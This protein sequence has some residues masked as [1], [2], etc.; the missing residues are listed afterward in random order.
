MSTQPLLAVEN[1]AVSFGRGPSEVKAVQGASFTV[2]HGE[3]VALVG[4]SGSGKSATALSIMR[5][6]PYPH[7]WHPSGTI[8]FQDE[9]LTRA[10]LKRM[11]ALRGNRI[12]MIFQE[13][14]T[15]LSP[16]HPVGR[17][18]EEVLAVHSADSRRHL[19]AR[20]AELLHLVGFEEAG[21]RLHALPHEFSGGQQQRL[22]I[23]IA[24]AN[25]PDLLIADEPTTA[26]DVTI[27]AQI[28][29][30]L[31]DL[32]GSLQMALLLIT[33]DLGIVRRIAE[34]VCV[35]KDGAIVE[36][37]PCAEVLSRPRHPYTQALLAAEP[38]GLPDPPPASAQ[39]LLRADAA[40]VWLPI[41]RGV[42]RRTVG[43]V[44][45]VDGVS[46]SV[47]EGHTLGVVG[48][49]GSGKSTLGRALLRL[50]KSEGVIAF[51]GQ[52]LQGFGWKAL[53]PLRRRMQI[54]FQD[55]FGSLSPRM[56]VGQ[57]VGEG[58]VIHRLCASKA[59]LEAAV[60]RALGEVGL[61]PE[62]QH[63]YPHEFSGGQRQRIAIARALVLKPKLIVLDEPTSA[64]DIS[65]QAQIV[66][67]L[68]T[69]QRTHGLA[70]IFISH[71]LRVVRA[72]AHDLLVLR[73]GRVVEQGPADAIFNR[74]SDP[75]TRALIAA[76]FDSP[77]PVV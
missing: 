43:H 35:M 11:Q 14:L 64:L 32:Q 73:A 63:R 30:L 16:L 45:A 59:E 31:K 7:A 24:L 77:L 38:K 4:E 18:I 54:V 76:A 36:Q 19:Q 48:E 67:L 62:A 41:R 9:D 51:E 28:L 47:R 70:Y 37:G 69:L 12:T 26:L 66:A 22:M 15:S 13:P 6:L 25:K 33:H 8:L 3:T 27:Q 34:R 65:V 20:V 2:G 39:E 5:L 40:K 42:L 46:V 57:I 23:A 10:P 44:K 29:A 75:Y 50:Q 49:S 71:D 17:Q 21:A 58:L 55:P 61:D 74:P 56:S 53:R 60:A 1:L 68:K 52:A 72:L